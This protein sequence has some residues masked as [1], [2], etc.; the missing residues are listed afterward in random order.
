MDAMEKI[1]E[2]ERLVPIASED[3]KKLKHL[4]ENMEK[5][6]KPVVA[7][8]GLYN[9]GKSSIL[10][11]LIDDLDNRTFKV[12]DKRETKRIEIKDMDDFVYMDTPGIDA[13][14]DDDR[15]VLDA[16]MDID[17]ILFVHNP[18]TGELA[19]K[20]VEFLH[21]IRKS[22]KDVRE[23]ADRTIFVLSRIDELEEGEVERVKNKIKSQIKE[24]LGADIYI[25]EVSAKRYFKGVK[26]NKNIF[27][28]KSGIVS[29]MDAIFTIIRLNAD[30]MMA[31]KKEKVI[32]TIDSIISNLNRRAKKLYKE[33]NILTQEKQK[34]ESDIFE[35]LWLI[36]STI[37][38][39][40]KA[41]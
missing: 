20:E 40:K 17:A 21:L 27:I 14:E 11:A 6:R 39:Y 24:Y 34:F 18:S 30:K 8:I 28:E 1:I 2:I 29:L 4:L 37:E 19:S 41:L 10:N 15:R 3:L 31:S 38:E 12:A 33:V 7:A 16:V 35:E 26:E 23:F 32:K 9:H 25:K 13:R 22:F 36:N 5:N